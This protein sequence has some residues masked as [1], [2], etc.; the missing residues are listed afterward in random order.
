MSL[1]HSI[2]L[3]LVAISALLGWSAPGRAQAPSPTTGTAHF[4]IFVRSAEIGT[5]ETQVSRDASG[6]RIVSSGRI[7]PPLDILTRTAE[8]RYDADWRPR[9]LTIN[10]MVAGR[11]L[12]LHTSVAGAEATTEVSNN[13]PTQTVT[14]P[15]D[16]TALLLPSP[17]FGTFEALAVRAR[18]APEGALIPI[19]S[20]PG[21]GYNAKVGPSAPERIQ[22]A[23]AIIDATRTNV[24]MLVPG[25]PPLD[26]EVWADGS[27]RL[28]RLRVPAQ[29]LE[30]VREDIGS[31]ASRRVVMARPNDE[32][33]RIPAVGFTLAGTIS[34]PLDAGT[35]PL[36]A[37]VLVGGSGPTDRDE[38]VYGIPI[39][40]Q[41]A[42]ELAD[43]GFLVLRYD[44]RGVGQS[45]GRPE[46]ATLE[47]YAEDLRGAVR[48]LDDRKDVD[49]RR[50]AVVGHSEGGMVAMITAEKENKVR[51]LVLIATPGVS[52][53]E[54]NLAQIRHA[55]E[56][57]GRSGEQLE[58][59]LA[60]QQK[61]QEAVLTGEGWDAIEPQLRARAD[62]PWFKSFLE[63]DPA[64]WMKDIDQ[65]IMIVQGELDTQVAPSNADRLRELAAARRKAPPPNVLEL[66]GI[67]HLLVPAK[68]GEVAEYA[69]L[70]DASISP[71]IAGAIA[72]WLKTTLP[73]RR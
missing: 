1:P 28:L 20:G 19:Y 50:I 68:T 11:P 51:A 9:E 18:S 4:K 59:T 45:G 16:D 29:T 17:Y 42:S 67:N 8:V 12:L 24:Q 63:F 66:P 39:F 2:R 49:D 46:A 57:A 34:R 65:P 26:V 44:K 36:P 58:T 61:I 71:V 41:L 6:W 33:V 25:A 37:V 22:T 31:V 3:A 21:A 72:D 54:L 13:G 10:A 7:A 48:F 23:A 64:R 32:Q 14:E 30:V 73:P 69:S 15:I 40:A 62:T 5:L 27:G 35:A 47:D 38:T 60:L 43:G 55:N 53:A 52:G 70:G 56:L